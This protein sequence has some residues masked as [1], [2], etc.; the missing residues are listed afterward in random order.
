MKFWNLNLE[1]AD[2]TK[3]Q[4]YC[5][6]LNMSVATVSSEVEQNE[7]V[8]FL[9]HFVKTET[10]HEGMYSFY[11]SLGRKMGTLFNFSLQF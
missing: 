1:G 7:L 4:Q 2:W 6:S 9:K 10:Q 5:G 3:A 8:K 11:I